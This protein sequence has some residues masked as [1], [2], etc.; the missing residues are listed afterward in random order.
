MSEIKYPYIGKSKS[1]GALVVFY[2]AG[3]GMCFRVD[4]W[5]GSLRNDYDESAFANVTCEVL[6]NACG[7]VL[8]NEYAEFVRLMAEINGFDTCSYIGISHIYRGG[9]MVHIDREEPPFTDFIFEGNCLFVGCGELP[10]ELRGV[11]ITDKK[12]VRIPLPP[13]VEISGVH[14]CKADEWP[15]V[16]D[17]VT[18]G[19]REIVGTLKCIDNG[20]AWILCPDGKHTQQ[21]VKY[22]K[23]PKTPEEKLR[24]ELDDCISDFQSQYHERE[25]IEYDR[26]AEYILSKYNITKK[27]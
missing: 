5:A 18:W 13:E 23:P 7:E 22:L 21:G 14:K 4:G 25:D 19:E 27:Q 3:C 16:G 2:G 6:T 15:Q 17:K 24:D 26:L 20:F 11:R 9:G 10:D 12:R 8:S 1:D